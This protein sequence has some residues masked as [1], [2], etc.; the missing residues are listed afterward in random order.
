M[1]KDTL[2]IEI[3]DIDEKGRGIGFRGLE[4]HGDI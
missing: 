2:N 3:K 1:R 4:V